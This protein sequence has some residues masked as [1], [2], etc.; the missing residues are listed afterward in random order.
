MKNP[1]NSKQAGNLRKMLKRPINRAVKEQTAGGVVF[2]RRGKR[3]QFLM[4]RDAKGRWTIPKGHV[5]PGE[6]TATTAGR[7]V[8]EETG[9]EKVKVLDWLG[10]IR[11]QYRRDDNLILMTQHNYLV[12]AQG[13]SDKIKKEAWMTDVRWMDAHEALEKV[14]YEQI[15]KLF[16][17]GLKKIRSH[18]Y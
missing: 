18:G 16:L 3:V 7:E 14:E 17:I 1:L 12:K 4:I 6:K 8:Q 13:D 5:E 9:L 2:R 10:K 11:F 15:S